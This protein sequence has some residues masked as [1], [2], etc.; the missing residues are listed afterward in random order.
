MP[1]WTIESPD[2]QV[3]NIPGTGDVPGANTLA[4]LFSGAVTPRGNAD[5]GNW[6]IMGTCP[7]IF[8][9]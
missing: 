2:E 6:R 9:P 3:V 7:D 5:G 8:P 1:R 4:S